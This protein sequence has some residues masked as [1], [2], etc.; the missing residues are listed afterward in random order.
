MATMAKINDS[1]I[2][3][4]IELAVFGSHSST[5]DLYSAGLLLHFLVTGKYMTSQTV[6]FG[7]PELNTL[8]EYNECYANDMESLRKHLSEGQQ[9]V[10][11]EAAF[12]FRFIKRATE[13]NHEKRFSFTELLS[14][15]SLM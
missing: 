13:P 5:S 12:L 2:T 11:P 14:V 3:I 10:D 9:L 6:L 1:I 15:R 4:C 8:K 7:K